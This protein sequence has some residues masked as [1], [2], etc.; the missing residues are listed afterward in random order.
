A[1]T[2]Q[3]LCNV[4]QTWVK[5]I[6]PEANVRN[7]EALYLPVALE[8]ALSLVPQLAFYDLTVKVFGPDAW[9]APR[10]LREGPEIL[11]GAVVAT[12]FWADNPSPVSQ[13]FVKQF[14]AAYSAPPSTLAAQA[15]DTL[16]LVAKIDG[17]LSRE[18]VSRDDFVNALL[19]EKGFPGVTGKA[20][21]EPDGE[22]RREPFF[23]K[24]D[25]GSL[26]KEE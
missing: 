2:G 13:A 14:I 5:M 12:G 7:L 1:R 19:R 6:A 4:S 8:D 15:F 18:N 17:A 25:Q 11:N 21:V 9:I 10:L 23:L 3:V 16:S 20:W 22:I 26:K 24:L